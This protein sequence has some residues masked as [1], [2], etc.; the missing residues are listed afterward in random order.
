V[1]FECDRLTLVERGPGLRFLERSSMITYRV[2]IHERTITPV[3]DTE[4]VV[5]DRVGFVL[6]GFLGPVPGY[7]RLNTAI[8]GALFRHRHRRLVRRW[9]PSSQTV[10]SAAT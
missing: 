4:C 9:T 10:R 3:S 1:P 5:R 2:W 7:H 6:R 8:V